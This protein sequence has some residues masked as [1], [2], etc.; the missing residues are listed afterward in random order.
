MAPRSEDPAGGVTAIRPM[1]SSGCHR[2][3]GGE[4]LRVTLAVAGFAENEL[5]V[6]VEANQ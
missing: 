3:K 1:T 2:K 4:R 6:S 5:D